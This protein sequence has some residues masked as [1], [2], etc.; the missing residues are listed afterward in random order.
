MK[1]KNVH[2]TWSNRGAHEPSLTW[3]F[4]QTSLDLTRYVSEKKTKKTM[5]TAA[6]SSSCPPNPCLNLPTAKRSSPTRRTRQIVMTSNPD[7]R[8]SSSRRGSY[9]SSSARSMTWED[10]TA[11]KENRIRVYL[12]LMNFANR[13]TEV[14]KQTV[15]WAWH[16]EE[17]ERRERQRV[18]WEKTEVRVV[19]IGED[20]VSWEV[21]G[22]WEHHLLSLSWGYRVGSPS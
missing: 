2:I 21:E 5:T 13:E 15:V 1:D 6:S 7:H 3:L 22:E 14:P 10:A 20:E 12:E 16:T 9:Y 11:A 19:V 18:V 4:S 17:G 8:P